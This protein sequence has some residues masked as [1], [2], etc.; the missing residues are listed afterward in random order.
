MSEVTAGVV[1]VNTFCRSDSKF[2]AGYIGYMNRDE[3]TR[4]EHVKDFDMFAGYMDYMGNHKKTLAEEEPEHISGLFTADSDLIQGKGIT[5]LRETYKQAQKN[6]SLMWQTVLS[7]DNR[8]LAD[9]GVFN[10][11]NGVLDE[12]RF[13]QAVRRSVGTLLKKE[14]LQ[15]G[16]W[17]AAIHYNTDNIHVH[18]AT[19]E[20]EPMREKKRY[21]QYEVIQV[22]GKWQYKRTVNP[23][24]GKKEKVPIL[25]ADGKILEKEEYVGRFK[26]SS[27][28]AMKSTMVE[29]LV[30][31]KDVNIRINALIREELVKSAKNYELYQDEDFRQA[32]LDIYQKLPDDK[33]ICNYGNNVMQPLRSEIDALSMQYIEKYQKEAYDEFLNLVSMQARKYATAYGKSKTEYIENKTNDLMY[34]MGNAIL[35]Q[36]KEMAKKEKQETGSRED[37]G[38]FFFQHTN[39][40]TE[41]DVSKLHEAAAAGNSYASYQLGVLYEKGKY[42]TAEPE[43][44]HEYY[45]AALTGFIKKLDEK[46]DDAALNF[47]IGMM[48]YTG[49]GTLVDYEKAL[50]FLE[51]AAEKGNSKAMYQVGKYYL[52]NGKS[53]EDREKGIAMLHQAAELQNSMAQYQ[54]GLWERKN[55][56][57]A[58]AEEWF[59]QSAAAGN[60]AAADSLTSMKAK[61]ERTYLKNLRFEAIKSD[62]EL[63]RALYWLQR[64]M[65]NVMEHCLNQRDYEELQREIHSDVSEEI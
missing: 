22:N 42:V 51:N 3:A 63:R 21:K 55:G 28:Q 27:L 7:F 46:K 19:V 17:S 1:A 58:A 43:K 20:P 18:I 38:T 59:T 52:N 40:L 53:D 33:R 13:K 57:R 50:C 11:D 49:K 5:D 64:S 36:M 29:Q 37:N 14:N 39:P 35:F 34:R 44:A 4:K 56:N 26:E 2:F 32:F 54:L 9:M 62:Q 16:I 8:W 6:G 12:K 31:D 23:K 65:Q 25:T 10:Q 41:E 60:E 61:D 15:N 30:Q 47:R 24:T 48:Y 45:A